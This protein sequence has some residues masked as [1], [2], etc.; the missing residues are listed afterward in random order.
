METT[1]G[2]IPNGSENQRNPNAPTF[3]ERSFEWI[4]SMEKARKSVWL[5]HKSVY[6][7]PGSY[8]FKPS[9]ASDVSSLSF[10]TSRE[11]EFI[12]DS[13]ASL[14]M[15]SKSDLTPGEQ[16]TA[17]KSKGPSVIMI[18]NGTTHATQVSHHISSRTSSVTPKKH[19]LFVVPRVQATE[20]QTKALDDRTR[21]QAVGDQGRI[22]ATSSKQIKR[23]AQFIHSFYQRP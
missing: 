23:K 17:Q 6:K 4:S 12:V 22:R 21:T 14:H 2:D 9:L 1:L 5:S 11:R 10:I 3:A 8:S 18:A 16:E 20:H 7:L 13:G 19:L 15:M